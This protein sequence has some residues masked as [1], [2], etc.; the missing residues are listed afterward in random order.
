MKRILLIAYIFLLSF[1][2]IFAQTVADTEV[3]IYNDV[4]S[5]FNSGFYPGTVEKVSLL[6]QYYPQSSYLLQARLKKGQALIYIKDYESAESVL[7]LAMLQLHSGSND[8]TLCN[9]LLGLANFYQKKYDAALNYF[10]TACKFEGSENKTELYLSSLLY[11]GRTYFILEDYKS[12]YPLFETIIQNGKHFTILEYKEALYKLLLCYNEVKLYSKGIALYNN[13]N[14]KERSLSEAT[15]DSTYL[16][17]LMLLT[18]Q[19]YENLENYKEAYELYNDVT[20]TGIQPQCIIS[21]KKAYKLASQNKIAD[22]PALIFEKTQKLFENQ[23]ELVCE[24]WIRLAVDEY[25]AKNYEKSLEYFKNAR[26]LIQS[27]VQTD[28]CVIYIYEAKINIEQRL[29]LEETEKELEKNKNQFL[30]SKTP[31]IKDSYYSVLMT[32]KQLNGKTEEVPL[33]YKKIEKPSDFDNYLNAAY[34]YSK[35]DYAKAISALDYLKNSDV[36]GKNYKNFSLYVLC[37][38]KTGN[39]IQ[40]NNCYSKMDS[41]LK[42]TSDDYLEWGK[43]LFMLGNYNKAFETAAKSDQGES[44]Y[45][46]GLCKINLKDYVLARDYFISYIK[47]TSNK[48]GFISLAIYYKGLAEYNQENFRDAYATFVRFT[49]ESG[50]SAKKYVKLAYEYAAKSAL[51]NKDFK[52]AAINAEN[53]IKYCITEEQKQNAVIFCTEIYT[54]SQNYE[55]AIALLAPYVDGKS[56]FSIKAL[57]ETAK[58]YEKQNNIS[59]A[60]QLY[61]KLY[62]SF[63]KSEYAELA[64]YRIGELYYVREDFSTAENRFNKYIYAFIDGKYS[65]SAL[66]Y[67]AD[68]NFRLGFYEKSIMINKTLLSKYED[69]IYAYGS[70]KNLLQA[71]IQQNSNVNALETAKIMVQKY[72]D[73]SAKDGI[74]RQVIELERI[75]NGVES[76]IA[77]KLSEYENNGKTSTKKGRK[78]GSELVK[79][80]AQNQNTQDQAYALA[81]ELLSKLT[82]DEI[83][84]KAQNAEYVATYLR[85]QYKNTDSALMF[86]KACEY[87]RGCSDAESLNAAACL[88]NSTEAFLA[89]NKVADAKETSLLLKDLYPDSRQAKKVDSLF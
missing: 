42:L 1:Y 4:V 89:D 57:F 48:E 52:N 9:Y 38:S 25:D 70:Y 67:C 68:C 72:P 28:P 58:I 13:I 71:Y 17:N 14:S 61:Q 45:V 6:E 24:F 85:S 3:S 83:Y 73:Q 15:S 75:S 33:L 63:P 22:N 47:K 84:L 80:Y 66:F 62:T 77:K 65:Q 8:F 60:E 50:G 21:L 32:V 88:Y 54:D 7:N 87:Y 37:L 12:A 39:Y 64:M 55:K 30:V 53:S 20:Q 81:N 23:K 82:E 27:G 36:N 41:K 46:C 31:G 5:S 18:A 51:Q 43:V 10:Y 69:S 34:F 56:D 29:Q 59:Q 74:G 11:S 79:L 16:C 76:D 2:S 86:L 78:A 35:K 40:A 44:D 26:V 49:K 19:L